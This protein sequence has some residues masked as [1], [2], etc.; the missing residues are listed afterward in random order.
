M[1]SHKLNPWWWP[2]DEG[3]RPKS[4]KSRLNLHRHKFGGKFDCFRPKK[5]E[6]QRRSSWQP[7]CKLGSNARS[8]SRIQ[9][10][11]KRA[12]NCFR[13]IWTLDPQSEVGLRGLTQEGDSINFRCRFTIATKRGRSHYKTSHLFY[14]PMYCVAKQKFYPLGH[15]TLTQFEV[16]LTYTCIIMINLRFCDNSDRYKCA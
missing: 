16:Y 1:R 8:N 2:L 12:P 6:L 5:K 13:G 4:G 3:P 15:S 9:F 11:F 7:R 14:K 10:C